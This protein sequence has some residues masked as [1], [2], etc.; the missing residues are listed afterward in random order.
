MD[1]I[2]EVGIHLEMIEAIEVEEAEEEVDV[3]EETEEETEAEVEV[4]EEEE[5]V[6]VIEMNVILIEIEIQI[7]ITI[8]IHHQIIGTHLLLH[9]VLLI[10]IKTRGEIQMIIKKAV[11]GEMQVQ[12]TITILTTTKNHL[13]GV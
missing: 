6:M 8:M 10:I 5:E 2:K 4:V 12:M 11:D 3:V 7:E 1:L 9:G 13:D